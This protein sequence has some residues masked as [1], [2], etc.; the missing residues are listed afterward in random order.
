MS[1]Y[2]SFFTPQ[3]NEPSKNNRADRRG[4]I[5][6]CSEI[7]SCQEGLIMRDAFDGGGGKCR[8]DLHAYA[9]HYS[10]AEQLKVISFTLI[11]SVARAVPALGRVC[12]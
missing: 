8:R 10:T 12:D 7:M 4:Q 5:S 3:F 1:E 6:R 2:L 9:W 11:K